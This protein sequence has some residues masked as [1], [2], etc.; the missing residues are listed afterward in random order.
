MNISMHTKKN[1]PIK[2]SQQILKKKCERE[3]KGLSNLFLIWKF[4]NVAPPVV[5]VFHGNVAVVALYP[6]DINLRL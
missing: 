4:L 2:D 5:I 3:K 6:G 1:G